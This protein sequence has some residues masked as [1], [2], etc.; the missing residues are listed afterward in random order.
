MIVAGGLVLSVI[1]ALWAARWLGKRE[2]Y[3]GFMGLPLRGT[4]AFFP[5]DAEGPARAL[6]PQG[7]GPGG[8]RLCG[9]SD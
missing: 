8:H 4:L 1:L 7:S 2:P 9:E 5:A 3:A 6:V